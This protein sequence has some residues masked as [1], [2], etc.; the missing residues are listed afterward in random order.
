MKQ[1]KTYA[2]DSFAVKK[3]RNFFCLRFRRKNS[4]KAFDGRKR[5]VVFCFECFSSLA[6]Y[7]KY[8][9]KTHMYREEEERKNIHMK[10]HAQLPTTFSS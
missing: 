6:V 4:K 8:K 2:F 5:K 7:F 9:N 3:A 10:A 1:A